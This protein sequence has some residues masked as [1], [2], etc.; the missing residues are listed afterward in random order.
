MPVVSVG[1]SPDWSAPTGAAAPVAAP[2]PVSLSQRTEATFTLARAP[3]RG[4]SRG[5]GADAVVVWGES[6]EGP[7]A[8][9][10]T[11]VRSWSPVRSRVGAV[12]RPPPPLAFTFQSTT[13]DL[14]PPLASVTV[15]V[16][17]YRVPRPSVPE[18]SP[19]EL[20][21]RPAGRFCADQVYGAVPL[22]AVAVT[23][24]TS[25]DLSALR[26]PVGAVIVGPGAT[27]QVNGLVGT[28]MPFASVAVTPA[29]KVPGVVGVPVIFPVRSMDSPVGRPDADQV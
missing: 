22:V 26:V 6:P 29:E 12:I 25:P 19:P 5:G 28:L 17:R 27:V 15:M 16:L 11:A 18:M 13:T 10:E 1:D 23:L 21:D 20:I 2:D 3:A 4:C 14:V 8:V 9:K 7:F 24:I